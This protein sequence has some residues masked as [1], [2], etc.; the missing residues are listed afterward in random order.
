M[1]RQSDITEKTKKIYDAGVSEYRKSYIHVSR[2]AEDFIQYIPK[3]GKI[4]EIGCG[5]G[6]DANFF[7]QKG[8]VVIATDISSQMIRQAQKDYPHPNITFLVADMFSLN[9]PNNEFDGLFG[10]SCVMYAFKAEVPK[11][12]KGFHKVLKKGGVLELGLQEGVSQEF[13]LPESF[14]PYEEALVNVFSRNEALKLLKNAGFSLIK[15]WST[16]PQPGQH[17]FKKL[18]IFARK[19]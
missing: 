12:L 6:V 5:V 4:L 18:K 3:G 9:F 17:P 1:S 8:H 2:S 13:F 10:E 11:L 15:D 19:V 16:M 14:P 7:A